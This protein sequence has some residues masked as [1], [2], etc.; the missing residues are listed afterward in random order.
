MCVIQLA[1][2]SKRDLTIRFNEGEIEFK[3]VWKNDAEKLVSFVN[4]RLS[5]ISEYFKKNK[6]GISNYQVLESF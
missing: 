2:A 6:I 3:D 4:R 5:K 1:A